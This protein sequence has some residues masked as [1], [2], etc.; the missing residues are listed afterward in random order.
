MTEIVSV[1]LDVE[2]LDD[3]SSRV[4]VQGV[5]AHG[6]PL[7]ALRPERIRNVVACFLG[8]DMRDVSA[9]RIWPDPVRPES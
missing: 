2:L 3:G 4:L 1:V 6:D 8:R 7:P 9:F 5:F